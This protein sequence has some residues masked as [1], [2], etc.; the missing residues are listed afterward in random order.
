MDSNA[1]WNDLAEA[2]EEA[3]E[4]PDLWEAACQ[5]AEDLLQWIKRG[6]FPP[7]GTG[8]KSFDRLVAMKACEAVLWMEIV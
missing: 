2:Y 4:N 7:D 3:L 5:K 8:V 1:A 6:G